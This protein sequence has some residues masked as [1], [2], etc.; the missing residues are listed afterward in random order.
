MF[1]RALSVTCH[2]ERDFTADATRAG[3]REKN[4]A[5]RVGWTSD[6]SNS[7]RAPTTTQSNDETKCDGC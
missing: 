7:N 3:N 6:A 4:E 1:I 5:R 2:G